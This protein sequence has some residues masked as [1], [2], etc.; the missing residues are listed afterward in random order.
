MTTALSLTDRP[1]VLVRRPAE[2]LNQGIV[3]FR[4]REPIDVEL[5]R[6]QWDAYVAVFADHGWGVVEVPLADELP[7]SVF[8]EDTTVVFGNLAVV[9]NP[10][11]PARN[12][13][14]APLPGVLEACGYEIARIEGEGTLDGGDILKIGTTVYAGHTG[15]TNAEGVRQLAAILEPRGYRVVAV[16]VTKALHLKSAVTA[17]P[18]GVVIGYGPVVDDPE[19]F[20]SYLEVPEE[21]GAHVVLLDDQTV[22]MSD[23]A[24]RTAELFAARGLRVVTVDIGEYEKLEGCVTCLS[25]RARG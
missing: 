8:I 10:G 4:E 23:K 1:F 5:A 22:L 2:T 21:P 17:L 25:I 13:E 18:D 11:A 19:I 15:T 7:D 9:T 20:D 6:R 16:P 14:I 3:T 12:P 24:P